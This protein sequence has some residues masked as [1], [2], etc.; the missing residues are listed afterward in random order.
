MYVIYYLIIWCILI[1]LLKLFIIKLRVLC[2]KFLFDYEIWFMCNFE[3]INMVINISIYVYV[4]NVKGYIEIW[5]IIVGLLD[6][7]KVYFCFNLWVF[8]I[9]KLI[10]FINY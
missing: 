6:F 10:I 8:F 5:F 2:L 3:K 9:N 7:V 4:N 1:D